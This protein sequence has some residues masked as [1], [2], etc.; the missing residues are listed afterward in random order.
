[1]KNWSIKNN[2]YLIKNLS[3]YNHICIYDGENINYN[4]N[5]DK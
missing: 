2:N 3:S 1:M 4:N 5:S